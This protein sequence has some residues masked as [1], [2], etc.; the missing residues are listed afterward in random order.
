MTENGSFQG[1]NQEKK[2]AT[3]VLLAGPPDWLRIPKSITGT[4]CVRHVRIFGMRSQAHSQSNSMDNY[5]T[6]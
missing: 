2:S 5:H 1:M 6:A 4:S 3:A